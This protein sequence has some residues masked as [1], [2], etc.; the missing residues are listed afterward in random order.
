MPKLMYMDK[1]Y[2]GSSATTAK[3][4][5]Y[6]NA[7]S[8][9]DATNA[10]EAIDEIKE[11]VDGKAEEVHK[12]KVS[13][14]SDLTA[15][16]TE[17]NY[18]DGVTSGVQGQ[19]NTL[20]NKIVSN[21]NEISALNSDLTGKQN[22]MRQSSAYTGDID[23]IGGT[24]GLP[25]D[26]S[27]CWIRVANITGALPAGFED[28]YGT[29]F[30]YKVGSGT[31]L[32]KLIGYPSG[33]E[34]RRTYINSAWTSWG[35]SY[36]E[37]ETDD[38]FQKIITGAAST[39]ADNNL[40]KDRVLVSNSSGKISVSSI[41]S[42]IL[43]YLSGLKSNVQNQLDTLT[44]NKAS[45]NRVT[46]LE[47]LLNGITS[48]MLGYLKNVKSDIQTQID[49]IKGY[50]VNSAYIGQV[51][52][53]SKN[54][55]NVEGK[56]MSPTNFPDGKFLVVLTYMGGANSPNGASLFVVSLSDASKNNVKIYEL[57][58]NMT[59][60]RPILKST[61]SGNVYFV[62]NGG[63]EKAIVYAKAISLT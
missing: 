41:T 62:R 32:Q 44:D 17:L 34:F 53:D 35:N 13:D 39:V 24:S 56:V 1:E 45:S 23:A 22:L 27:F 4:L 8:N 6:N 19:I 30:T 59:N 18:M 55:I 7:N 16:V 52:E 25:S 46:T 49:D 58:Y 14:I 28:N 26:D 54:Y 43:G 50:G 31:Y 51:W 20:N 3:Q 11:I 60:D 48:P 5:G 42:T 33:N 12:H 38:I 15:T 47:N 63:T 36:T 9:L 29:L 37:D 2:S 61:S 40:T 57:A 10:Q 21:T